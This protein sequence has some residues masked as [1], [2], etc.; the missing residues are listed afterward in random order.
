MSKDMLSKEQAEVIAAGLL[1]QE[2]RFRNSLLASLIPTLVLLQRVSSGWS[3][4][5]PSPFVSP[6]S[7]AWGVIHRNTD[8]TKTE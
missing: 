3:R 8:T 6:A 2:P 4:E 5:E 7:P 1:A